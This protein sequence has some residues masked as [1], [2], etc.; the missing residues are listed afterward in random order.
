MEDVAPS[1]Q[2]SGAA[3]QLHDEA[4]GLQDIFNPADKSTISTR[5]SL[6]AWGVKCRSAG[7]PVPG[8]SVE[9]VA[10]ASEG[11]YIRA[12]SATAERASFRNLLQ[13]SKA[14]VTS[15]ERELLNC[16]TNVNELAAPKS[17]LEDIMISGETRLKGL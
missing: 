8:T 15:L 6:A 4:C 1:E 10:L 13:T 9:M 16:R 17:S 14:R 5:E 3:N 7:F 11:M 12:S 2:D